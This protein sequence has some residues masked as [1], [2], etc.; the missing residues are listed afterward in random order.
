M[1]SGNDRGG[2]RSPASPEN[3]E[4]WLREILA[5]ADGFVGFL[6]PDGRVL[7]FNRAEPGRDA[8]EIVGRWMGDFFEGDDRTA[9]ARTLERVARDR[10]TRE[11]VATSALGTRLRYRFTPLGAPGTVT[12]ILAVG[13]DPDRVRALQVQ[14]TGLELA[15]EASGMGLWSWD[16]VSNEIVWDATTKRIYGWDP[17]RDDITLD[18]IIAITHEED[19]ELVRNHVEQTLR[20]CRYEPVEMRLRVDGQVRWILGTGRVLTDDEGS[21]TGLIGGV[22]DITH[23]KRTQERQA[24]ANKLEALGRLAGGVAHDLNNLLLA[25]LGNLDLASDSPS[26]KERDLVIEQ[27]MQA[28][29]R[30]SDLTRRLLAFARRKD[31]VRSR[32]DLVAYLKNTAS[33][34]Q[35]VLPETIEFSVACCAGPVPVQID[36]GQMEQVILNLCLNA[37]D[38]L[39]AK[40]GGRLEVACRRTGPRETLPAA[41]GFVPSGA[42]VLT[43]TDTGEGIPPEHL[44]RLFDPFFTTRQDGT[45]LGLASVY[46]IVRNHGGIVEVDSKPAAGSTFR[47]YLPA[48]SASDSEPAP[49]ARRPRIEPGAGE[50]I[51][52]A[53]DDPSVRKTL[54]RIL[55]SSGYRVVETKDGVEALERFEALA[56]E[57]DA[58]LL[59]A[60]MPRMSGSQVA[61]AVLERRPALPVI[62]S[63]GYLGSVAEPLAAQ[64]D[65]PD[66]NYSFLEK[67]YTPSKLLETLRRALLH[68]PSHTSQRP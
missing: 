3:L 35:R 15:L 30:A 45:G 44:D 59:D 27:A 10:N 16:V 50:T 63:S 51:L 14:Q 36:E 38:A 7:F 49:A 52:L 32:T 5:Q 21:P 55:R 34:L 25:I 47:I 24:Q 39:E 22:L 11:L 9:V 58:V 8:R 56:D 19:R 66:V 68:R 64:S 20:T 37:R 26:P 62:L 17:D 29:H 65:S 54:A 60:V 61:Q 57:I 53:E 67:P 48:D 13:S 6:S 41:L 33:L 1:T 12:S 4:R 23:Q 40:G 28:C 31:S 42:A 43:V 2:R 46:G 18:E